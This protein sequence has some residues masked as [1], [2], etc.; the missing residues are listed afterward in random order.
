MCRHLLLPGLLHGF[1][2]RLR[3][4]C[5]W[6]SAFTRRLAF[7]LAQPQL[8]DAFAEELTEPLNIVGTGERRTVFPA[9]DIEREGSSNA[10]GDLLLGPALS[11]ACSFEQAIGG[12]LCCFLDHDP[13]PLFPHA[14]GTP[15]YTV[16]S[17]G[18]SIPLKSSIPFL[19]MKPCE[20]TTYDKDV[21]SSRNLPGGII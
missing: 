21:L 3:E 14:A 11:L 12:S 10:V 5:W 6:G 18:G 20:D 4:W 19:A 2:E 8:A 13:L 1:G 9:T 15:E 7:E 16:F 17:P